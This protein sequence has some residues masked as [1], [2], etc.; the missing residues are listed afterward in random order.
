MRKVKLT[1]K[2]REKEIK[3]QIAYQAHKE[4]TGKA[5]Q[6][7]SAGQP[8][9]AAGGSWGHLLCRFDV[10]FE[11]I[12]QPAVVVIADHVLERAEVVHPDLQAA[13]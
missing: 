8:S 11:H 10:Q 5:A 7:L 4:S 13:D 9:G 3:S 2:Y 1:N 12:H 6:A